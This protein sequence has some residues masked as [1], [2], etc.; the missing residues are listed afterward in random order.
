MTFPLAGLLRVRG[1]QERVAAEE[2][3]RARADARAAEAAEQHA[4]S[5]LSALAT[6]IDDPA[7]LRAMA[8]ARAAGQAS[9]ADLQ[10]LSRLRRT[11]A[12]EAEDAHVDARREL[13]GLER[14]EG[15]HRS[16]ELEERARTEQ[17]ALDEIATTRAGR[18]EGSAA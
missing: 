18:S 4:V 9:L 2:A 17:K 3:A 6:Q 10:I 8:A 15:A 1:V 11:E 16:R 14:L 7:T 12:A 5:S 13:K